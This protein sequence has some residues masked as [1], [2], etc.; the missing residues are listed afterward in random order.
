MKYIGWAHRV[1]DSWPHGR[2]LLRLPRPVIVDPMVSWGTVLK[3]KYTFA[4]FDV[5]V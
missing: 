5:L 3:M 2:L 1:G 4:T